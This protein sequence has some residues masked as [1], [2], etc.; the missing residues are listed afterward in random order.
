MNGAI[1]AKKSSAAT[2]AILPP[3]MVIT[4]APIS[5]MTMSICDDMVCMSTTNPPS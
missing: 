3:N 2:G 5:K 4:A 1:K